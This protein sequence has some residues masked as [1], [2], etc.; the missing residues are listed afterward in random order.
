MLEVGNCVVPYNSSEDGKFNPIPC[1]AACALDAPPSARFM[2]TPVSAEKL[3]N[4]IRL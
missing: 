2:L 3:L 1:I 4:S